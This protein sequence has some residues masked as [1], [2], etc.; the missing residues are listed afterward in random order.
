MFNFYQP[1]V[2]NEINRYLH[3]YH[4]QKKSPDRGDLLSIATIN[5]DLHIFRVF[6]KT[7]KYKIG[8]RDD[9]QRLLTYPTS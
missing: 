4:Y 9:A 1:N 2:K 5:L 8:L 6:Y 3:L 7:E